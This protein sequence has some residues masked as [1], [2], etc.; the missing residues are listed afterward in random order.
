MSLNESQWVSMS[1][2]ES[3]W[4][5][6]ILSES[7]FPL[8]IV[9]QMSLSEPQWVWKSSKGK[10]RIQLLKRS[11][12]WA[13]HTGNNLH[14]N[15]KLHTGRAL[16]VWKP[17]QTGFPLKQLLHISI[18]PLYMKCVRVELNSHEIFVLWGKS[19]SEFSQYTVVW[20]F[21]ILRAIN[22][23]HFEAPKYF[24]PFWQLRI[25]SF[26]EFLTFSSDNSQKSKINTFWPEIDQNWFHIKLEW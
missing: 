14:T 21:K 7:N 17:F 2:N 26:W 19:F 8:A 3:L 4:V 24:W 5:S 13:G 9:L 25:L 20:Q 15:E 23:S 1:L 18:S 12:L 10:M 6:S 11:C 22:F 16:K